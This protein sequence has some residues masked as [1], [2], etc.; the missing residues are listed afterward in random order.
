M[1]ISLFLL[2]TLLV[3][4][5]DNINYN[6]NNKDITDLMKYKQSLLLVEATSILKRFNFHLI[7]KKNNV[8]HI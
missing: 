7:L 4:C 1:V 8:N 3:D 6:N 2:H 5:I